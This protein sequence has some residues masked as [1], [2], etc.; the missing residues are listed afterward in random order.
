MSDLAIIAGQGALPGLLAGHLAA[1]G[2]APRVLAPEGFE[3]EGIAAESFRFEGLA[4]MLAGLR[5]YGIARVCLAGAIRRPALDPSRIE[6]ASLPLIGRL[7]AVMG[8]GDDALL[9]EVVAV[10]ETAGLAVVGA[11]EVM[12]ELVTPPPG[13]A[14]EALAGDAA[15]GRA[16][17]DAL[18]PLDVGQAVVVAGGLCLGIETVQGTEALLDFVARTRRGAG[19]GGVLVKRAKPGQELRVDMPAIGPATLAQARAAGLAG[20]AIEAGK[21]L[22]MERE[23]LLAEAEAAGIALWAE[24]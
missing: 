1:R 12:P 22:L 17:L 24:P 11:A 20:I 5:A 18:G 15:R 7:A 9:R 3:P 14:P 16:I 10:F 8:R 23:R 2:D 4:S 13:R 19:K 21:V 6:P